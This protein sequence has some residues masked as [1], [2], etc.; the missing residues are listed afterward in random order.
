M[1]KELSNSMNHTANELDPVNFDKPRPPLSIKPIYADKGNG[2]VNSEIPEFD[3]KHKRSDRDYETKMKR[4]DESRREGDESKSR[5]YHERDRDRSSRYRSERNYKEYVRDDHHRYRS[6]RNRSRSTSRERFD[7]NSRNY[8]DN[9][10]KDESNSRDKKSFDSSDSDIGKSKFEKNSKPDFRQDVDLESNKPREKVPVSVEDLIKLKKNDEEQTKPVF[11]TKEERQKAALEKRKKIVEQQKLDQKNELEQ[12]QKILK[13]FGNDNKSSRSDSNKTRSRNRRNSRSRSR[14]PKISRE[15]SRRLDM[16][17]RTKEMEMKAIRERYIGGE[18]VKR[19]IRKMNDKNFVFDWDAKED[20]SQDYNSLYSSRHE[21]Q[22]FGRGHIAG[23][24]IKEQMA[25]KSQFY[26]QLLSERRTKEE[27]GRAKEL[28]SILRKKEA[29]SKWDDRHWSEKPLSEMKERDWRIFKEDFNISCKGGSIPNP[30]RSWD[31]TNLPKNILS[32][33]KKVGY[34]VPTPIQRQAIPIGL[35]NRDII[36]IA[37]T[38]SGK[39][40]SFLIP[41]LVYI[42]GLPKINESNMNDGPYSIILAPTRELALQIEQEALK[43][44]KLLGFTCV[45]IVGGHSID[46][47]SFALRNGAEIIIATPGRLKDCIDRRIIVLNQTTYV[48]MDEADRMIDMGF[49]ED[50][51][52]ILDA[53][54]SSQLKPDSQ[55]A[56]NPTKMLQSHSGTPLRYRQTTMF[57]A[58]MPP[59]VER[60]ARKYLRRPAIVTIGTA[61]QAVDTV[62]QRVEFISSVERKRI[63]L[64]ELLSE[65]YTPPVIIFV[66]LKKTADS[67][68]KLVSNEGHVSVVLHGGKSQEQR[69]AALAKLKSGDADL[70]I[71]TD[72]AGRGIDVKDVS[73]VINFDM[74]KSIEDYTHRIGRTGRA[75]KQGTAI[76][77]LTNEDSDV[78]YDLR[79]MIEK[80][81]ISRCPMELIQHEASQAPPGVIRTKRRYEE[82]LYKE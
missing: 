23:F 82:T 54:P 22:F 42:M 47:Q 8:F 63:R 55:D 21:P 25:K 65:N 45:S 80:S 68:S 58:T 69:E 32:V 38:G 26:S 15:K 30:I 73:L 75:G 72:V 49:E 52:F 76:T 12:V 77:F 31:E 27:S 10:V 3:S 64:M 34:D 4:S 35:Q 18:K 33:I 2:H 56:E 66:N 16:E 29:K 48:V 39:T 11:M 40:A 37:E 79:K 67:L 24:D 71:A 43:F 41:M 81:P 13:I 74:A 70:L 57:S 19:K 14:S 17:Q 36:G 59:L 44:T 20:T 6:S 50:V 9:D 53:L 62:D 1:A 78:F 60:L 51:N 7:R 28:E 5:S 61:G 46:E